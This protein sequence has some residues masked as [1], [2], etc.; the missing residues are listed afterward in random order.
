MASNLPCPGS[1]IRSGG[2]GQGLGR[3]GGQGP[4]GVPIK[5][6]L[7]ALA[8]ILKEKKKK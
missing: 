7:A 1:K 6:K 8:K 3:G 5:A 2:L 4:I